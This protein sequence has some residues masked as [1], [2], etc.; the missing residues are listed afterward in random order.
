MKKYV[1]RNNKVRRGIIIKQHEGLKDCFEMEIDGEGY[2]PRTYQEIVPKYCVFDNS[3][4]CSDAI[5]DDI[6]HLE[7]LAIKLEQEV[8]PTVS[9]SG[10]KMKWEQHL[11]DMDVKA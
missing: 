5:R 2:G 4:L 3:D 10:G 11:K 8:N 6:D 7:R 9:Q 1:Y